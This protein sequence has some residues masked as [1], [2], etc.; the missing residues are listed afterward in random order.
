MC[1]GANGVAMQCNKLSLSVITIKDIVQKINPSNIKHSLFKSI[2]SSYKEP[3]RFDLIV[4]FFIKKAFSLKIFK[5]YNYWKYYVHLQ[6]QLLKYKFKNKNYYIENMK[7]I[8]AYYQKDL[9]K[10]KK[11]YLYNNLKKFNYIN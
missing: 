6:D 11:S 8:N 5:L 7:L 2:F 10:L 4:L 3:F 1:D 9:S